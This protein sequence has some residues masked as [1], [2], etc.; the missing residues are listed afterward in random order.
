MRPEFRR[1]AQL[2]THALVDAKQNE[3]NAKTVV[4]TSSQRVYRVNIYG[5]RGGH[6]ARA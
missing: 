4:T 6:L 3:N 1:I 5:R 2:C